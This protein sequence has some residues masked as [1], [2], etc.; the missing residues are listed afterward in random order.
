MNLLGFLRLSYV[1]KMHGPGIGQV[2]IY[3]ITL[4]HLVFAK[5]VAKMLSKMRHLCGTL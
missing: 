1:F 2:Y 5:S 3:L 4:T